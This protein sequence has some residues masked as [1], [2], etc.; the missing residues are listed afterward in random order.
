MGR[1][2]SYCLD[3]QIHAKEV[4][5]HRPIQLTVNQSC[6]QKCVHRNSGL[7]GIHWTF[8]DLI[9]IG[10]ASNIY[11]LTPIPNNIRNW[12]LQPFSQVY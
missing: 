4:D 3:H 8:Y 6:F 12:P 1:T 11:S 5:D 2:Y 9:W 10:I 7:L